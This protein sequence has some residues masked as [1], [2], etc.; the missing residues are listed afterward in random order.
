M[1]KIKI[2]QIGIGH[3]HGSEKM[4]TVLNFP[5]VYKVVGVCE[6]DPVW[7]KS[8]GALDVYRGLPFM[9]EEELLNVPSLDAVMIEPDVWDLIPTA[10]RCIDCGLHV[11]VDNPAGEDRAEFEKLLS[12]AKRKNL[13]VQLAYMYRYNNAVQYAH[14][15]AVLDLDK[16][17]AEQTAAVIVFLASDEA[18]FVTGADY[19]VDGGRT[20]GPRGA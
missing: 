14:D 1:K 11:H 19:L 3:N 6:G 17:K 18:S 20:L 12:D 16:E 4:R 13:V 15:M 7:I 8:R 9:C 10:Q 2:A 5:E